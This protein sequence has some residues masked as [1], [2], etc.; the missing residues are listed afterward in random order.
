[1]Y[2]SAAG[3]A[4]EPGSGGVARRT[5]VD[6]PTGSRGLAAPAGLATAA[7][8]IALWLIIDPHTPDLAAQ[9]YRVEMFRQ[10]GFAVWDE[11]WYAGHHLPGYSL[12][13]PPL[14][15][16]LGIRLVGALSVLASV[17]LFE[18]ISSTFF[19]RP[20]RLATAWF[21]VAAVGDVWVGRVAFALGV[22]LALAAALAALRGRLMVAAMLAAL[23]AAASPVAGAL[24]GLAAL[25]AAL[26][27]RS[28][29]ILLTLAAPAAAIVVALALMFPEGGFEPYPI[30]S[31]LATALVVVAFLWAL[32]SDQPLLRV[33]GSLYLLACLAC[34]LVHSPIGSNIERYGV[35]LAGP[36]L[37]CSRPRPSAASAAALCAAAV[38]GLWGPVRETVAVGGGE[39]TRAA[40]Y[41]PVEG[42]LASRAAGP[43]RVEVPLTRSH[44]EAALLAPTVSLARGWEKQ[45]DERYDGVLLGSGLTAAAYLRWLHEQA[46]AYVAVPDAPLD[47]SSAQEGRLIARG[48]PY[49]REVFTSRH[50]RVYRVLA[51][52]PLA[53]GP[54]RL[55]LLGHDSFALRAVSAGRFRLRLRFTPYWTV[56]RGSGCVREAP[57]GWTSVTAHA[58]GTVLVGAR[59]SLARAFGGSA[60]SCGSPGHS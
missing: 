46:V 14:G 43:V 31:F 19:G 59:F 12:L 55:T 8:L 5:P 25:S 29:R 52:T 26:T 32:P 37:L 9:V 38:W 1:V 45:L 28:P 39:S 4:D 24:L 11:H 56:V 47:P 44:W 30:R 27:R 34:L 50:W 17:A 60:G 3:L 41:A 36:L 23:C 40:Y 42:F 33:G 49:L 54:G 7:L 58:P 22:S 16:L 35:L 57:G 18:R 2:A 53:S 10:L 6:L 48:L 21:A 13:F 51:P 20:A 15:S